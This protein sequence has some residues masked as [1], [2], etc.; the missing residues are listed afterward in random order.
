VRDGEREPPVPPPKNPP[1]R[2]LDRWG[3]PSSVTSTRWLMCPNGV[4]S[5]PASV[6]GR[7]KD[8]SNLEIP[9]FRLC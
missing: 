3:T 9:S 5:K 2:E 1:N 8:H 6:A 7:M 4:R